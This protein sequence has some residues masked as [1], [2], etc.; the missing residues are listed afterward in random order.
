MTSTGKKSKI[1][2]RMA[3]TGEVYSVA[4]R[5]IEAGADIPAIPKPSGTPKKFDVSYTL[6][7]DGSLEFDAAT[8]ANALSDTRRQIL[9]EAV[10][11]LLDEEFA[12]SGGQG[13]AE[14]VE[15]GELVYAAKADIEN[16]AEYD[17]ETTEFA[18]SLYA[19]TSEGGAWPSGL[20]RPSARKSYVIE[21]GDVE[22]VVLRDHG[23]AILA[24]FDIA[25]GRYKRLDA[26]PTEI[27]AR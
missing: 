26:W 18:S 11:A 7:R 13:I 24:V 19:S 2:Q 23:S 21:H 10:E 5:A 15:G 22:Y 1:R 3:A 20:P 16:Q 8:W 25:G 9:E 27:E 17:A 12:R 6:N 4:K 14:C